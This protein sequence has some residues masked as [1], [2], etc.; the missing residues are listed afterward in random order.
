MA[1]YLFKIAGLLILAIILPVALFLAAAGIGAVIPRQSVDYSDKASSDRLHDI[2]QPDITIYLLTS[3]LHA[4]I[5]VPFSLSLIQAFPDL[6]DTN[7]PLQNPQ[8]KYLGFG[9]GSKAFYTTAGDY[10]DIRFSTA[11]RA[12]TGD[13]SV[14][15]IVAL[16]EL[17]VSNS[18]IPVKLKPWQ[19]R[20]LIENLKNGFSLGNKGSLEYL[21]QYSIG[22]GDAFFAG[23][24]HF[25]ILYPCN[26]WAA[27]VL[28]ASGVTL[29]SWTP[30][31]YSLVW[32]LQWNGELAR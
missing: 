13:N 10:S 31:T 32:S 28:F 17:A 29:G 22:P 30:T 4:D 18:I 1:R 16:P 14:M 27:D 6:L 25:D 20:L 24:G 26:Q 5:A 7:L 21:P 9:W 15:R 23:A 2:R 8:L 3:P 19:Y 11:Y 12:I